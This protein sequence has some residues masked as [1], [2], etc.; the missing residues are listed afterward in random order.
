MR[1]G[2]RS[3][4]GLLGGSVLAGFLSAEPPKS[5]LPVEIVFTQKT[6]AAAARERVVILDRHGQI[7]QVGGKFHQTADPEV[8]YDGKR[9]LFAAQRTPS[10]RWQIFEM[11]ADGAGVRQITRAAADCRR[12]V[13]Q[14]RFFTID[15]PSPWDQVAYVSGGQIWTVKLDGSDARQVTFLP[16]EV[17]ETTMAPDGRLLFSARVDQRPARLF[18]INHD[19]TDYALYAPGG[20]AGQ[21]TPAIAGNR[22]VFVDSHGA[23]ASLSRLRPMKVPQALTP[24]G[25]FATPSDFGEGH[26]L[27]SHKSTATYGLWD[28]DPVTG[29]KILIHQDPGRDALQAKR[30]APRTLPDGRGSVVD[31]TIHTAALYCLSVYTGDAAAPKPGSV[32][33]VRVYAGN[34]ALPLGEAPVEADGSFHVQVPS[35]TP[36]FVELIG[37]SGQPLRRSGS[38]YARSKESRGCIG[39]HENPEL[40]PENREAQAIIKPAADL[41][42]RGGTQ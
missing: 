20:P 30:I 34:P 25:G 23:L 27:V 32:R 3:R 9:I 1:L 33:A 14:S 28:L 17:L 22:V 24:G 2:A 41:T 7:R 6:S 31:D 40:T 36:L 37:E 5:S 38:F 12:P 35:N 39:C 13:Y 42:H 10:D 29:R 4:I 18:G 16:G 19:G 26:L 21:R 15:A 8:S 11:N